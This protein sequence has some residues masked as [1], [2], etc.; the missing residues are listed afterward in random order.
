MKFYLL[1]ITLC[2][3]FSN[4]LHAQHTLQRKGLTFGLG[5]GA[6]YLLLKTD[7]KS[8]SQFS[9]T[10][11][12][13]KIGYMLNKRSEILLILPG[14]NY[15]YLTKQRGFEGF[16]LSYQTWIK[17]K[18][19]VLAGAGVTFD[20]PAFY[21]VSDPKTA[22]FYTGLPALS[23][24]SGYEFYQRK[25]M[26]LDLQYRFFYGHATIENNINRHGISN[27]VILGINWY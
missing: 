2:L 22:G 4:I 26:A 20:A 8:L 14:A 13:I 16:V 5:A 21:T 23:V 24:A 7:N 25:H 6:G 15:T 3:P 18:W 19:W 17:P 1:L 27:M 12:N 10:L 9:T 11:P